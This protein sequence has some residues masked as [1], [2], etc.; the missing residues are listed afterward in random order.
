M[1]RNVAL[2]LVAASGKPTLRALIWRK[3]DPARLTDLWHF[4]GLSNTA[5]ALASDLAHC[6]KQCLEV[7]MLLVEEVD[8]LLLDESTAGMTKGQTATISALIRRLTSEFG[9]AVLAIEHDMQL[10]LDPG[11]QI[12]VMARGA[13]LADG[14]SDEGRNTPQVIEC[15]VLMWD[16]KLATHAC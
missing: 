10:M 7:V 12:A 16:L 14:S 8:L 9:D 11:C 3:A 13:V 2:P 4:A 1:R 15:S 6:D 5:D